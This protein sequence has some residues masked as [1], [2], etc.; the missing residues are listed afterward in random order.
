MIA[1]G[2]GRNVLLQTGI[3]ITVSAS[4]D[5][6]F[7]MVGNTIDW[8][9]VVALSAPYT[10]PSGV[11]VPSGAKMLRYG[12]V[13]TFASGNTASNTLTLY[14]T[15]TGGTFTVT[16]A[17]PDG[18]QQTTNPLAYNVSTANLV[19]ALLGLPNVGVGVTGTPGTTYNI[20]LPT[21]LSN[22]VL[23]L[24][25]GSL[26]GG[27]A[28]LSGNPTTGYTITST[29][30]GGTF[31]LTLTTTVN[32][33]VTSVTSS[34]ITASASLPTLSVLAA[35]IQALS[36]VGAPTVTGTPGS[37][38]VITLGAG[39]RN[40]NFFSNGS[41]LSG[42][43]VQPFTA[44]GVSATEGGMIGPYDPSA[45]DG[46]QTLAIGSV[47]ILN[48]TIV[49]GGLFG[50]T[51]FNTTQTGLLEG[52]HV[53]LP[54]VIQAGTGSASLAAGPTLASLLAVMPRLTPFQL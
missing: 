6:Q 28:T 23:S 25:G 24:N 20:A 17:T 45:S 22:P 7:G 13:M 5:A 49:Q 18:V 39:A 32:G 50:I 29:A 54:R 34:G 38:Y 16:V 21:S 48:E 14:N 11:F 36:N 40:S 31:T 46:R 19:T 27:T 4:D 37:S 42:A 12:Q 2:I 15:P 30:T 1:T 53:Y 52:G 41:A 44:F 43:G 33:V 8:N 51:T 35:D 26:T 3:P 9:L 10:D 47:G